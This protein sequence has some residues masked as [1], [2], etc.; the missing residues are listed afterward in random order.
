[1][2]RKRRKIW[3]VVLLSLVTLGFTFGGVGLPAFAQQ[4]ITIS[5]IDNGG[6][7]ASPE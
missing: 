5:I 6:D 1:M 7:L 3:R 4:P 2:R